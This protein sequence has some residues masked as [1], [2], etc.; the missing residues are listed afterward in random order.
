MEERGGG[1]VPGSDRS[2]LMTADVRTDPDGAVST[3]TGVRKT[4]VWELLNGV[5]T[6]SSFAWRCHQPIQGSKSIRTGPRCS[7]FYFQSSVEKVSD[8]HTDL[9]EKL[10]NACKKVRSLSKWEVSQS[11]PVMCCSPLCHDVKITSICPQCHFISGFNLET[12]A[13]PAQQ[14]NTRCEE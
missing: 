6:K 1:L 9:W 13:S 12:S 3:F 10:L 14:L 4:T 2:L 11:S 7:G 5:C 8:S